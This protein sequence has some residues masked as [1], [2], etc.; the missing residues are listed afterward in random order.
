MEVLH[1]SGKQKR[2][3]GYN[4]TPESRVQLVRAPFMA[5]EKRFSG[6]AL[7]KFY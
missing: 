4:Q 5:V 3:R 2:Y 7:E 6:T 1:I